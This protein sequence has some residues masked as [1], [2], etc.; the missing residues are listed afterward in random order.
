MLIHNKTH[1]DA[2]PCTTRGACSFGCV[3]AHQPTR[4][5]FK[6]TEKVLL[7]NRAAHHQGATCSSPG[8]TYHPY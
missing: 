2:Q 4:G 7:V 8:Q 3:A 5:S 6:Q 1:P